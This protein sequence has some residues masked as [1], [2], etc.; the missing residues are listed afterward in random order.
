MSS[1]FRVLPAVLVLTFAGIA[2]AEPAP[3]PAPAPPAPVQASTAE[4]RKLSDAFVAVAEKVSPAVVQIDVTTRD[5]NDERLSHMLGIGGDSNTPIHRGMG[6]GVVFT[7]DGGIL[8]NNHVIDEALTI[9]V[10]LKDGRYMPAKLVG[11][12]PATDLAVVK[13]DAQGLPTAKLAD[14]DASRV[15]EWVVAIGSPF[16]LGYSV[17]SGVLSA[18]GRGGIGANAIEDYLQTDA[19]INP[20][21]SG[22]PLCNL[23]G[24]VVGINSMIVGRGTGIGF[25]VPSNIAKRVGE[26]ILKTGRVQRAWIGVGYQDLTPDLATAMKVPAG[27][28]ALINSIS[29]GSPAQK[30]AIK[31]GDIIAS[32]AGKPVKG[33]HE[34]I[35]EILAHDVGQQIQLEIVRDGK[36]YGTNVVLTARPEAAVAPVPAQQAVIPQSGMGL[37]VRDLTPQQA[38]QMGLSPKAVAVVTTVQPGSSADRAGIKSG[39]VVAEADGVAD[40]NSAQIQQQAADGTLLL[41]MRRGEGAFYAVIRR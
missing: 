15:G 33:G 35:R 38:A 41:R 40:P 12:D 23:D 26:Q 25:A 30:S 21:N 37:S 5:D 16:G 39:D 31:A 36:H 1:K 20:G 7:P 29:D 32:V 22:G 8:T 24:Q 14:S 10:R 6:S 13:I 34:L 9:N 27:S 18:K 4:A 3:K 11:R 2:A 19:S 17:T 28:G